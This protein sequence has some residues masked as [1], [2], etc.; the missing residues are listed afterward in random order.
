MNEVPL[1]A[2]NPKPETLQPLRSKH[3]QVQLLNSKP[4]SDT[5]SSSG[6]ALSNALPEP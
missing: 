2:L 5:L 1:W 6:A 3:R 4:E